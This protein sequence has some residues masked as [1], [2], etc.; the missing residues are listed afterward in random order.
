MITPSSNFWTL[1]KKTE[2][3]LSASE[4]LAIMNVAALAPEGRFI[5]LGTYHGKS[6][7]SAAQTLKEGIF[8][9]V[10]PIFADDH[11]SFAVHQNIIL[12]R[13]KEDEFVIGLRAG[14]STDVIPEETG[15]AYVFVDS[16]SHQDGLP[17]QEV[18]LLEDRVMSGGI[19]AFHDFRSQ[20]VEVEQAYDYLLSTDKF[21][22]IKIDWNEI[23]A[24]AKE[25]NLEKDNSSWHHCE[26]EFPC[27]VGALKRK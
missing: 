8:L 1:F 12:S 18:K 23:V 26:I 27:F 5:E 16:G 9:L 10:D 25:N 19:V 14:Y 22:E 3:A 11:L 17:M 20:F 6:A 7:M 13:E 2:G 15:Y 4:S 24:Y 21:E